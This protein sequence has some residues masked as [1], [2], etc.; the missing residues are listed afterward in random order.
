MI[1]THKITLIWK[2][3]QILSLKKNIIQHYIIEY[4]P[5]TVRQNWIWKQYKCSAKLWWMMVRCACVTYW[6][7]VAF[8]WPH[9]A[10][11]A[12]FS[13]SASWAMRSI[14]VCTETS[15]RFNSA[16]SSVPGLQCAGKRGGWVGGR[17]GILY[18]FTHRYMKGKNTANIFD[19]RVNICAKQ[20]SHL[21][22]SQLLLQT[23]HILLL[24]FNLLLKSVRH[25]L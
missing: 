24:C 8:R 21:P 22:V 5:T 13:R 3:I 7:T 23:C 9:S 20:Y 6:T 2:E 10:M 18:D 15:S 25:R 1:F 17:D 19:K 16:T 14:S 11:A 4:K 12:S